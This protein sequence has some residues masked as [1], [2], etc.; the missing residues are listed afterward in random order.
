MLDWAYCPSQSQLIQRGQNLISLDGVWPKMEWVC[1][2]C[3]LNCWNMI[4][5][6]WSKASFTTKQFD[7]WFG[8]LFRFEL[9][10]LFLLTKNWLWPR[11]KNSSIASL[12]CWVKRSMICF[13]SF[14]LND[15][16]EQM[17]SLPLL[18]N[19]DLLCRKCHPNVNLV[20]TVGLQRNWRANWFSTGSPNRL[21]ITN[22]ETAMEPFWWKR[23]K[24]CLS[25]M[26]SECAPGINFIMWMW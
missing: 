26:T 22:P 2:Q 25:V 21:P 24:I 11:K 1:L 18:L 19:W 9:F 6:C 8:I 16:K 15:V 4:V 7:C 13:C 17:H 3:V 20:I 10:F 23:G 12:L 5:T 14:S